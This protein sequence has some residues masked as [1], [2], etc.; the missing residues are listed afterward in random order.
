MP[1]RRKIFCSHFTGASANTGGQ[2]PPSGIR[3]YEKS[4]GNG[5]SAGSKR[6]DHFSGKQAGIH[7]PIRS[8]KVADWPASRKGFGD[9]PFATERS[10]RSFSVAPY[11]P[12]TH[13]HPVCAVSE[14]TKSRIPE[15]AAKI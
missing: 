10:Y 7:L 13:K 4:S 9:S 11:I 12:R 3:V 1:W 2:T 5:W 8:W 15:P 6:A 14:R